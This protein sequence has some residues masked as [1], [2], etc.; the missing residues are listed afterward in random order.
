MS[1]SMFGKSGTVYA[2]AWELR[3]FF[4]CLKRRNHGEI[5]RNGV[6]TLC[7][8]GRVQE[9]QDGFVSGLLSDL[10]QVCPAGE[11]AAFEPQKT[12]VDGNEG[13]IL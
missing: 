4:C 12:K 6:F 2:I 11:S 13:E 8:G 5:S 7:G 1:I 9:G 3:L 10:R